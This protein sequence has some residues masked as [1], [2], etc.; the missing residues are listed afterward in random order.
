MTKNF[1][2]S[3]GS[4]VHEQKGACVVVN[5]RTAKPAGNHQLSEERIRE[6]ADSLQ[7]EFGVPF[8]FWDPTTGELVGGDV[9]SPPEMSQFAKSNGD[10]KAR[11]YRAN[12][13]HC[14]L[15]L[16]VLETGQPPLIACAEIPSL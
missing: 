6:T 7:K 11:A 16:P 14:F 12:S 4:R 15:S 2:R 3:P 1:K 5:E 8:T 9:Q 13:G 10:F